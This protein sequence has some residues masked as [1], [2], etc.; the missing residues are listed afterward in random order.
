MNS[1]GGDLGA[2]AMDALAGW[3]TPQAHQGPNNGENRGKNHGGKRTRNTPQNVTDL[4]TGWTTPCASDGE[5]GP[6]Q[7]QQGGTPLAGQALMAGWATPAARDHKSEEATAEFNRERD[8]HARG[9]PL[10]YQ[11][12]GA[13]PD[14]STA[15]TEKPAAYRLNPSFSLWLMGYPIEWASCGA[16][17]MQLSRKMRRPSSKRTA[18][19][20]DSEP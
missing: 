10:S 19:R 20:K 7:F 11:A 14:S 9:K 2:V 3:P 8:A 15:A 12:T 13:T 1:G 5:H 16:R 4:M 18:K 6:A 17:A